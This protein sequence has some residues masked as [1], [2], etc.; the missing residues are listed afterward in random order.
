[1]SPSTEL[2]PHWEERPLGDLFEILD[3]RRVPVNA[4]ERATRQGN[5]PYFGATGQVGWIDDFIFDEELVLLGEDGAPFLDGAKPKAYVIRGKTWVNNHAHV[6]RALGGTPSNFWK[7]QLDRVQYR[8][9]VSGTTRLKLPQAP[10]RAIP[11]CVPPLKEQ[12]RL[13]GAL[14]SY[15]TR[16]DDAEA[17][18]GHVKRNLE[19]YRAS[20]L[21]AAFKGRLVPT[22]AEVAR[23]ECRAY[24]KASDLAE[25][26]REATNVSPNNRWA[27]QGEVLI[28]NPTSLPEGW[29]WVRLGEAFQILDGRRIPVNALD[30]QERLGHVPYYGATGRVGWI[31]D[32]LFDEELLL[33]GEDGA[34]FLDPNKP[35]GYVVRGKSWVNN[36]AHVLRAVGDTSAVFWKYQLDQ[37]D[38]RPF[39]SGTTRLKLPQG[40]MRQIPLALPPLAEQRRIAETVEQLLSIANQLESAITATFDRA[41]MLRSSILRVAFDGRL[42]D[43][44]PSDEPTSILLDRIRAERAKGIFS[45]EQRRHRARMYKVAKK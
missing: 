35:K 10:M 34:P 26:M 1:M 2:P 25:R 32:Y 27:G 44:D 22:E 40:P 7:Y 39:V 15:F 23:A 3:S 13:A 18:L 38:F 4:K 45:N 19:R 28:D 31:D 5:V 17:T 11:L 30:R 42:V 29:C 21:R 33:L 12:Q 6:L 9:F 36:H 41:K 20:I 24:E 43:Q 16:L 37:V 8:P 14:D